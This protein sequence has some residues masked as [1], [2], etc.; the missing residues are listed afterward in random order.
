MMRSS[1]F[2]ILILLCTTL[3]FSACKS[4]VINKSGNA[5]KAKLAQVL[6]K[7]VMERPISKMHSM[8]LTTERSR[9]IICSERLEICKQYSK[10]MAMIIEYSRDGK[11]SGDEFRTLK[12]E[13]SILKQMK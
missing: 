10:T 12:K 1:F 6:D 8:T 7:L 4:E 13:V 2:L 9:A 11:L 5:K 3:L